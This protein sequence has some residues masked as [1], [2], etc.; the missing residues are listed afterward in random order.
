LEWVVTL[1]TS[2]V[3]LAVIAFASQATRYQRSIIARLRRPTAFAAALA[4]MPVSTTQLAFSPVGAETWRVGR[5]DL[6]WS[7]VTTD[8]T[9]ALILACAAG[10]ALTLVLPR[11]TWFP[12]MIVSMPFLG[13]W[14]ANR[15][16][17]QEEEV[18]AQSRPLWVMKSCR[19]SASQQLSIFSPAR[20]QRSA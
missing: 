13:V 12:L 18:T 1:V 6:F 16:W 17:E 14:F 2:W 20:L 5:L 9:I 19:R 7:S 4:Y 10:G 11:P 3:L 15:A 8:L